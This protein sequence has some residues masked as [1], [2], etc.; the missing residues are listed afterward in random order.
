MAYFPDTQPVEE[1]PDSTPTPSRS[2]DGILVDVDDH[3]AVE[4]HAVCSRIM[5]HAVESHA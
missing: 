3:E 5:H 1:D 2:P 4:S